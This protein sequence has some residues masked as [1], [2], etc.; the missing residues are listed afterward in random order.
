M[1]LPDIDWEEVLFQFHL[2]VLPLFFLLSAFVFKFKDSM[3]LSLCLGSLPLK[4]LRSVGSTPTPPGGHATGRWE[5]GSCF[6]DSHCDSCI[7]P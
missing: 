1:V 4:I 6:G 5:S 7:T 3:S 2:T